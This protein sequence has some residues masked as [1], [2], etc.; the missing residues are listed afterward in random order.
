MLANNPDTPAQFGSLGRDVHKPAT[1]GH[2][3]LDFI[4]GELPG[5]RDRSDRPRE[6]SETIL[7]SQLCAHLNSAARHSA[8]WDI[9]QF[10]VEEADEQHKGRKIDLVAS[11]CGVTIC[12]EGRKHIDFESLM[13]IE[14]KRLP[15]PHGSDRDERE[16]VISQY[17]STGGI[18]RFKAGDHGARHRLGGMVGYVQSETTAVWDARV[19]GWITALA[20]E[21]PGWSLKDLLRAE[22]ADASLR[23][24]V[25]RSS[26]ERQRGMSEIELRHFWIEMN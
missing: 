2:E 15:T 6:T 26:H 13:P 18:Q 22:H 16:Y 10:R 5:W 11:P 4:A 25:Y 12:I 3:L 24:A 14:C 17:S 7:T 19:A 20:G 21:Q 8:G 23:M 9:L 1:F